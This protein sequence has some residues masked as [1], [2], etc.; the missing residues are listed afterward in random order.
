MAKEPANS[1]KLFGLVGKNI[2]YSFSR[3]YFTEKFKEL[4]LQ[5]YNYINFDIQQI[6]DFKSIFKE[7]D[8][9]KGLNVTIP[10]KEAVIPHLQK[11]HKTAKNIG[12]VNTIKPTKKGLK[13]YNT[14]YYG[15]KKSIKPFL[16]KHHTHALILGT[17]GASK[18][19]KYALDKLCIKHVSVSRTPKENCITYDG[20]DKKIIQRHTIII[21]C[22]PLGTFPN[23]EAKPDIPYQHITNKHLLYDLIY[24][25]EETTFLKL[26]KEKGATICNGY[27]MLVFQAEKAWKIWNK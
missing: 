5:N 7:H 25:P 11:L 3:G 2:S 8:N 6:E 24:N 15:F 12:A 18:A 26:G 14:D 13:G 17:G 4:Q 10:Y 1:N 19:V 9:I 22:T 23:I 27:Q 16:K 21:N 20:L